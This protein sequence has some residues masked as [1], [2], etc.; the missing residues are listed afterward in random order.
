MQAPIRPFPAPAG[1]VLSTVLFLFAFLVVGCGTNAAAVAQTFG[2][3][4]SSVEQTARDDAPSGADEIVMYSLTTCRNSTARRAS[5]ERQDI[6]FTEYF[7]DDDRKRAREMWAKLFESGYRSHEIRTPIVVVNGHAL[8]NNPSMQEIRQ[9]MNAPDADATPAMPAFQSPSSKER[10]LHVLVNNYRRENGLPPVPLSKSL[11]HVARLHAQDLASNP[12]QGACN[13][14]SWSD[15]GPWA[16]C[17]YTDDHTGAICAQSKPEELTRY[18]ARGYEN[19][20][21]GTSSPDAALRSWKNSPGH[22]ALLLNQGTWADNDWQ[23]M[24]VGIHGTYV[25]LW[26]G[27][28]RDPDGYWGTSDE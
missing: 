17:C 9:H 13:L 23:A 22:N 21:S 12:P 14:H 27:E 15:D 1:L 5:F 26:F 3:G 7:I 6:A 18:G 20:Y 8:P 25:L 24:G 4:G 2:A 19:A 16:A 10:T 11:S 28:E